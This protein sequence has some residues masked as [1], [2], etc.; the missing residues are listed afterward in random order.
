M[1][2]HER[3]QQSMREALIQADLARVNNEVPI[4]AVII[5]N[6]TGNIITAARNETET[7]QDPSAHAEVLAI[8]A[9]T[10]I[11]NNWRLSECSLI[12]TAEPC[13]MCAGIILQSRI[14]VIVF[15]CDEPKTGAVGSL[16]DLLSSNNV[17]VIRGV[18][19]EECKTILQAFFKS[20]RQET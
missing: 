14:P 18:L 5:D 19:A 2:N 6:S 13:T 8:Q 9:A 17:R 16:Y 10:K 20:R 11:K 1:T 15:G 12:V 7:R 3:Y 4:G